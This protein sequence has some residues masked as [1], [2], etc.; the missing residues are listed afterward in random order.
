MHSPTSPTT[1]HPSE[2]MD[3]SESQHN[4]KKTTP[5]NGNSFSTTTKG[6]F[7]LKSSAPKEPSKLRFGFAAESDPDSPPPAKPAFDTPAPAHPDQPRA[8]SSSL[9]APKPPAILSRSA[10][11]APSMATITPLPEAGPSTA[12]KSIVKDPKQAALL[13]DPAS[14][15]SFSFNPPTGLQSPLRHAKE[16]SA[17]LTADT[18]SLPTFAF[19]FGAKPASVGFNWEGAGMKRP[20]RAAGSWTCGTC[21]VDND[22]AKSK[23]ISC[24]EPRADSAM[25]GAATAPAAIPERPKPAAP[26]GGFNWA[27]AGLKAPTK[28]PETW[29]CK[30]CM[31]DNDA[32]KTKCVSCEE[33]RPD[34]ALAPKKDTPLVLTAAAELPPA[35]TMLSG[36][37]NWAAAGLKMPMKAPG[38]W[39]CK[40]CMVDNDTTKMKCVSCEEPRA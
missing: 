12:T 19:T 29:T 40:V 26:A 7:P 10:P 5:V 9:S 21:M 31:V 13:L 38:T 4:A 18:S 28:A 25:K 24:E 16:R 17:A 27:A 32:T 30:V 22:A 39:T 36:G 34:S 20:T 11:S 23:C 3:A 37:F 8:P 1:T 33:P 14:L 2:G 15:P 35:T 6:S